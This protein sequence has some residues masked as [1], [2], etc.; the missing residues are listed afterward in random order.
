MLSYV[1]PESKG[2]YSTE[3]ALEELKGDECA[4]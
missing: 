2:V 3:L 4:M 1:D